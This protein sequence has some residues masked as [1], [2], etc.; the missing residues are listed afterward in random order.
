MGM[1]VHGSNPDSKV[2]NC[3][4]RNIWGWSA[5]WGYCASVCPEAAGL[6]IGA[7]VNDGEGLD[8]TDAKKL[9]ATAADYGREPTRE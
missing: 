8:A 1:R 2:G 6:G 9:A 4:R 5:L 7:Y 3:F